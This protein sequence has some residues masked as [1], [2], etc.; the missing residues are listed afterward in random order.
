MRNNL[1]PAV[2]DLH[3]HTKHSCDSQ[4]EL[5]A[6]C[7]Q[8]LQTGV[9]TLCFTDHVDYNVND[10]G[11]GYY[12][13]EAFF[14]DFLRAKEKYGARL[15]LLCGIEFSEPH[16]YR[17]ELAAL[18][19]LPYDYILGSVHYWYRDMFPSLMVRECVPIETCYA[20][21]WDEVLAAV[22]AGG[23][24]A[25]GHMDFPKRYYNQLLFDHD[26]IHE[27]CIAMLKNHICPE[28]NTS[29]LRKNAD[30]PMPG[31][32][33]LGIYKSCGGKYV[34][35]GSD[36]H[37]PEELAAGNA[38]ARELI[39]YFGFEEINFMQREAREIVCH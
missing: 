8:A 22:R 13:P 15:T 27:I 10:Y 32:D 2:C 9:D 29:S 26:K 3:V 37:R 25:L 1:H 35:V 11:Y 12:D 23:F 19:K 24:D 39:E 38:Q 17:E 28:I 4:A 18:S 6:H 31:R 14:G 5:E 36:A 20:H 16:L 34:T 21:Y 7:I 30:E 33:I